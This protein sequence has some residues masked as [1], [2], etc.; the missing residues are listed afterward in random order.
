M[1]RSPQN[2]PCRAPKKKAI[3][4]G[5]VPLRQSY[6]AKVGR[7]QGWR[8]SLSWLFRLLGASLSEH[9]IGALR[10]LGAKKGLEGRE[11]ER[12]QLGPGTLKHKPQKLFRD[13]LATKDGPKPLKP[14][15]RQVSEPTGQAE[16]SEI[17]KTPTNDHGHR[18]R[19]TS[20]SCR[21]STRL[22]FP[23]GS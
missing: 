14:Q 23:G 7:P 6:G 18:S 20:K 2:S 8:T 21:S 19:V 10:S 12:I 22:V 13:I 5:Q 15:E 11:A 1:A 4:G 9:L 16:E 17:D 3:F